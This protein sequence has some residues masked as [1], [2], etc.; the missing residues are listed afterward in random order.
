MTKFRRF[1]DPSNDALVAYLS[2]G[3]AISMIVRAAGM[4]TAFLSHLVLSRMLGAAQ[5]GHYVIALGWA[6]VLVVPAR[7]GLDNTALRFA[8]IYRDEGRTDALRG[9]VYFSLMVIA[10]ASLLIALVLVIAKQLGA[11]PLREIDAR[12]V[13]GVASLVF[14]LAALGWLSALVRTASQIFASQ[15]YEQL[16]RPGLLIVA[17]ISVSFWRQLDAALAMVVTS[18][19][20]V[21]ALL[22]MSIGAR[23]ILAQGKRSS[24]VDRKMWLSVSWVLFLMAAVQELLNQVDLILLGLMANA[25]EAAHFAAAWRLASLVP[26][27]LAAIVTVSGPLIASAHNQGDRAEMARIARLNARFSTVFA[28]VVASVL[29]IAGRTI[30]GLFGPGFESAYP[31]LVIMLAGG[32]ANAFTGSVGYFLALTG[33]QRIAL[34]ILSGALIVSVLL[35]VL[36]IPTF[37]ATGSAVAS[38]VAIMVWNFIMVIYV[39]KRIGIDSTVVGLRPA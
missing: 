19:T 7:L 10:G 12:L 25:T 26:F 32:I 4:A 39:R 3:S 15:F 9:L 16:L 24:F 20:A 31:A 30:L 33:H 14:P 28:V 1:F 2:K 35:N 29:L 17:L 11:P 18:A 38:T 13:L 22:S 6:M 36:L 27:G 5:Y 8:T 21:V 23:R 34:L 37:G